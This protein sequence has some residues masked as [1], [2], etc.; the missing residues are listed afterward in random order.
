MVIKII[1]KNR[2]KHCINLENCS[3]ICTGGTEKAEAVDVDGGGDDE[4]VSIKKTNDEIQHQS[5]SIYIRWFNL[6]K[7]GWNRENIY[8]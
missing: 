6:D 3:N 2:T 1:A 7:K 4:G 8:N 5:K